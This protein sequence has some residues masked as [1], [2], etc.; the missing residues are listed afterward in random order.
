MQLDHKSIHL[1]YKHSNYIKLLFIESNQMMSKSFPPKF[2][3]AINCMDGRIQEAVIQFLKQYYNVAYVDNIT[4]AGPSLI[5]FEGHKHA[6]IESV[7][8]KIKISV[9]HHQSIGIAVVGHTEC[10]GNPAPKE[11]QVAHIMQG[12]N[13]LQTFY[14]DLPII[15]LWVDNTWQVHQIS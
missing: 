8:D 5:L 10:A 6:L 3:T 13:F 12:I 4:E 9:D 15:G 14:P 7:L 1:Y 2:C 11:E